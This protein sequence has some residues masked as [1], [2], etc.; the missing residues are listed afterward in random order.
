MLGLSGRPISAATITEEDR[1]EVLR[2]LIRSCPRCSAPLSKGGHH[3]WRIAGELVKGSRIKPATLI[4]D[5]IT[6]REWAAANKYEEW[7]PQQDV[8]EY[9]ALRCPNG[10][11]SLLIIVFVFFL[12]AND[13]VEATKALDLESA[14]SLQS[15]VGDRWEAL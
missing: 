15:Y 8:R 4:Q 11:I 1:R 2:N 9:R 6:R 13:Y 10:E 5:L 3:A 12:W 14:A 7:H